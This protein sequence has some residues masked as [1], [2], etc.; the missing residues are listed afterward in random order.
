M[1]CLNELPRY[2]FPAPGQ[3]QLA[4]QGLT[5]QMDE[6]VGHSKTP[7]LPTPRTPCS[8]WQ[9]L[10][11]FV[12]RLA[13]VGS[14]GKQSGALSQELEAFSGS[15]CIGLPST[16]ELC[17]TD[18]RL[19]SAWAEA[20]CF[21]DGPDQALKQEMETVKGRIQATRNLSLKTF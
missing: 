19:H 16:G 14:K 9:T 15:L 2:Q 13:W 8:D 1:F 20:L 18:Q 12:G 10:S 4:A 7:W 6:I 5:H 3:Q 17:P 11:S 21:A